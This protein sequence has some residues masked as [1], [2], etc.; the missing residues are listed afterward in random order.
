VDTQS[1]VS[2]GA[3]SLSIHY[4]SPIL[5]KRV[6]IFTAFDLIYP[7]N[8]RHK[9]DKEIVMDDSDDVS[10]STYQDDLDYEDSRTDPIMNELGEDPTEE[11]GVP[12]EEFRDEL[13]KYDTDDEIDDDDS[14]ETMEDLDEDDD[15]AASNF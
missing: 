3:G 7:H 14:R 11:L 1:P 12:P 10:S 4:Y 6:M 8:K 2:A 13:G 9:L 5:H 15:N